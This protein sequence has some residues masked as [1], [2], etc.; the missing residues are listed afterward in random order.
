MLGSGAGIIEKSGNTRVAVYI[1]RP[2]I[3]AR[4]SRDA[5]RLFR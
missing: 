4:D 1:I 2:A 3:G 5:R